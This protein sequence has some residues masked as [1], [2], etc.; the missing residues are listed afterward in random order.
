MD[1]QIAFYPKLEQARTAE[2]NLTVADIHT[3]V[4]S[5]EERDAGKDEIV[6]KY[7]FSYSTYGQSRP[8]AT[9][10]TQNSRQSASSLSF[11]SAM[12]SWSRLIRYRRFSRV[13]LSSTWVASSSLW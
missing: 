8:V 7:R 1:N 10:S 3:G 4:L 12:R 13:S 9:T 5:V 11:S 2:N 6:L